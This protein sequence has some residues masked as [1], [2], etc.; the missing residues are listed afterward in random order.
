MDKN[1]TSSDLGKALGLDPT[2]RKSSYRIIATTLQKFLY[3]SAGELAG[4]GKRF[5]VIIDEAHGSTSGKNMASMN[6]A[7][8]SGG[9]QIRYWTSWPN[10]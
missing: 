10:L 3:L 2:K 7:L 1:K 4:S 6:A 9:N 5:V 8:G